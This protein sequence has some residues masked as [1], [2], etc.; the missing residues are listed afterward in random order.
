[1]KLYLA[2]AVL[3]LAFVAYTEAQEVT[4]EERFN[5]LGQQMSEFGK[6]VAEKAKT[7]LDGLNNNENVQKAKSWFQEQFQKMQEHF[8]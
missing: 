1:M 4:M 5:N 7:A 6:T 2:I 3:V 8:N